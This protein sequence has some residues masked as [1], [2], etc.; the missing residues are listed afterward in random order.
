VNLSKKERIHWLQIFE[1]V[2]YLD[3]MSDFG[4]VPLRAINN[5]QGLFT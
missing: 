1:Q 3:V 2:E 4:F 5:P